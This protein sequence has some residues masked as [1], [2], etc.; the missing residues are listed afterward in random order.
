AAGA[1]LE[2]LDIG[3]LRRKGDLHAAS[4]LAGLGRNR[5]PEHVA[6]PYPVLGAFEAS[7][8]ATQRSAA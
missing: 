5:L 8:L 7:T 2:S 3:R 6:R 4:L 1:Y